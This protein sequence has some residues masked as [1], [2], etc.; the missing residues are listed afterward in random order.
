[1]GRMHCRTNSR[2]AP[3]AL[4]RTCR[5]G[6]SAPAYLKEFQSS[7]TFPSSRG[8]FRSGL[9]LTLFGCSAVALLGCG[10]IEL[11]THGAGTLAA[12]PGTVAFG[13]VTVGHASHA[14]ISLQVGS[15]GPVQITQ[16][17]LIGQG[18]AISGHA[19]LPITVPSSGSYD[20]EVEFDPVATGSATGSLTITNSSSTNGT[21]TIPLVGTGIA[22][23]YAVDLSWDAPTISA[24]RVAGFNVYRSPSGASAYQLLNLSIDT[25]TTYTDGTVQ[26]GE[27]YDYIVESVDDYGVESVPTSPV[28]VTIP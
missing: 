25:Q 18:F 6:L 13:N 4:D 26:N 17:S 21:V 2:V 19:G 3:G 22:S 8:R 16:L 10:E 15:S 7:R 28:A 11:A 24:V 23:S 9:L 27:S 20:L 1:M 12:T 14:T 5:T